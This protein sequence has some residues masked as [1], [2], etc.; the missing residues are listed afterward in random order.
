MYTNFPLYPTSI[1]SNTDY[2]AQGDNTD[3]VYAA[4]INAL[5][6]EMQSCFAELGTLPKGEHISIKARLDAIDAQLKTELDYMEYA[7]N[8]A[9]QAA[10]VSSDTGYGSDIF[11]GGTA[12]DDGNLGPA[13]T[14]A[15]AFDGDPATFYH[16]DNPNTLPSWVKYNLGS[17]SGK[18]ITKVTITTRDS[19]EYAQQSAKDFTIQ[20]SN[21]DTDWVTLKAVTNATW[22]QGSQNSYTFTNTTEYRYY[23]IN[24]TAVLSGS[25]CS[26]S[27]IEG[28][29]PNLQCYS[30]DTIK[31]QG[32]YSL[33]VIAAKTESLSDTLI[34]T[35]DPVKDLTG[36]MSITLWARSDRTGENFKVEYHDSG[37]ETISYTVNILVV[38][39]WEKK[40][41]DISAVVDAN[42]DTIDQIKY[43]IL[44]AD[45]A[46]EIYLDD[47]FS[48]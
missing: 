24:I 40:S 12:T 7:S 2:P 36:K 10:Y 39:T 30:E 17:G 33:K 38:G 29:E 28:F 14:A 4:L 6:T 8:T 34:R 41:I 46:A 22:T 15:K 13:Y 16:T 18:V 42:K 44:N 11:T 9:A 3:T 19:F 43:T 31:E 26:I 47:N 48:T 1:F 23:K 45:A 5:K 37:G 35:L 32:T 27:E 20:G 21:N 25:L